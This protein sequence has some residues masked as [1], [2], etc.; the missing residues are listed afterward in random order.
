MVDSKIQESLEAKIKILNETLW[1]YRALN[2]SIEKW[3]AN[4]STDEEKI[5]A[6]YLLSKFMYFGAVPMRNLLK[7]LYRDLYRYPLIASIRKSN[8]NTLDKDIIELKFKEEE[9]NTRF[10]GV[11]NPSESGAHL[12]YFFRQENKLSKKLFIYTDEA[13]DRNGGVATLHFPDVKHYVFIDDFCGSGSQAT[14]NNNIKNCVDNLRNLSSN[15]KISYL[16]LFATSD[17]IK[18]VKDSGLYDSV[19]AVIELDKTYKCFDANS[20]LFPQRDDFPFEKDFTKEFCFRLGRPLFRSINQKEGFAGAELETLSDITALGWGD[21]QLLLGFYHNTPDNT[22]PIIW[23][24][25]DEIDWFPIF[26]R[27]NKKYNL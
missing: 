10:L 1:D 15:V 26:R 18:N 3:L 22:L 21:C 23:Y 17:G 6:L 27:Y 20:R 25:E 5:H 8:N 9:K 4:F 16:M 2:P 12:L 19:K 14:S 11:G 7:S 13:I 24:D